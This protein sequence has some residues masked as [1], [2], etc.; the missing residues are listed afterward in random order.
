MGNNL[1]KGVGECMYLLQR[2]ASLEA[3]EEFMCQLKDD[4]RLFKII[5]DNDINIDDV[6]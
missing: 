2:V 1:L 4:E 5:E 3:R 6:F